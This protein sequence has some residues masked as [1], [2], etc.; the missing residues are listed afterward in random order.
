NKEKQHM[1]LLR[2]KKSPQLRGSTTYN[3]YYGQK[4]NLIFKK[5]SGKI[6]KYLIAPYLYGFN[7]KA[8]KNAISVSKNK[9]KQH[10]LLLRSK[11]SPQLRGSTTYII[12]YG[13]KND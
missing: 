11:K 10:M 13:Q 9:E 1:L 5:E 4:N 3:I 12:Y 2:S 8:I 7:D 6:L